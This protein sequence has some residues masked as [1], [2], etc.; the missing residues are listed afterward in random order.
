MSAD[1]WLLLIAS[2]LLGGFL[3]GLLGVGG[4]TIYVFV[5]E[6]L[7]PTLGIT[8]ELPAFVVANSL[9]GVLVASVAAS[10]ELHRKG[11]L[12]IGPS[13]WAGLPSLVVSLAISIFIVQQSWFS[14]EVFAWILIGLLGYALVRMLMPQKLGQPPVEVKSLKNSQFVVAGAAGGGVAALSGLGGGI[15]MVPLFH[16]YHK[17]SMHASKAIS[18]GCITLTATALTVGNLLGNAPEA[19]PSPVGYILLPVAGAIGM[20]V[21]FASPLGVRAGRKLPAQTIRRVYA[22]FLILFLTKKVIDLTGW[23]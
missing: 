3:A 11:E 2:G 19:G 14:K 17:L 23:L 15:V 9:V 21:L 13:L 20:G 12:P 5:L 7:L 18:L 22:L 8:E 16:L 10:L 6:L 1:L 4:G